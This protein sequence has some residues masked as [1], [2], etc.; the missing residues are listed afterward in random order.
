[1]HP[2]PSPGWADFTIM[3]EFTPESGPSPFWMLCGV[4]VVEEGGGGEEGE[5][6]IFPLVSVRSA[7]NPPLIGKAENNELLHGHEK[8][9]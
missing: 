8:M 3:L 7:I 6:C 4:F 1:V 9:I 5:Q 2:P